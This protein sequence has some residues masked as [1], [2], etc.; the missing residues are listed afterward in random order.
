M[1]TK[2]RKLFWIEFSNKILLEKIIENY[3]EKVFFESQFLKLFLENHFW[4][5]IKHYSSFLILCLILK[6]CQ[7]IGRKNNKSINEK[8]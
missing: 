1:E 8:N 6:N 2:L 4:E 3:F 5:L 7:E